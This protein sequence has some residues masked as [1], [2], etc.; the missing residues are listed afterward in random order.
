MGSASLW[1]RLLESLG[2]LSL[3]VC[4]SEIMLLN[5]ATVLNS[6]ML[7]FRALSGHISVVFN[8]LQFTLKEKSQLVY[9]KSQ[10]FVQDERRQLR[11]DI[12]INNY[13]L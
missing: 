10:L 11:Y 13:K 5:V 8:V 6:Q 7:Q 12:E 9:F 3:S 4:L 2:I 1:F